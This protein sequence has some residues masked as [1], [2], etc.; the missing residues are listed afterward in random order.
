MAS[1]QAGR[2]IEAETLLDEASTAA[3]RMTAPVNAGEMNFMIV[4]T[5]G[6]RRAGPRRVCLAC[7]P[8]AAE[9]HVDD[10]SS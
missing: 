5:D 3:V 1:A 8:V 9:G 7:L 10:S 4:T 2:R 6:P